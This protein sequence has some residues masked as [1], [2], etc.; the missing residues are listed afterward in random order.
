MA[1]G[2]TQIVNSPGKARNGQAKRS[3]KTV[4]P[5]NAVASNP[6]RLTPLW[7]AFFFILATALFSL[8]PRI[9]DNVRLAMSFRAAAGV[10]LVLLLLLRAQ[11][12]RTGRKLTYDFKPRSV[13]YVQLV[14]HTCVY[15]YWGW[16]WRE[17]Y[18][19]IPLIIGQIVFAYALDMIVNWFR[20]DDYV[21][22]FGPFPIILSTNLFLWF[23]DDYFYWQFVLISV[24]VLGKE[25]I[26]WKRDGRMTHIFNPS[27]LSLFVFS[28][29]LLAT[30]NT[31][32]TWGIEI[33]STF[34][35][36]PHIYMELFL[37]GLVVQALF[38]VTLVTLAAAAA[39]LL[40]N[41]AYTHTT[42]VYHF[43]DSNI[44]VAVFLGL[45]LLVTDPATSP[46][47]NFGKIIFGALYGLGVF[48]AYSALGWFGAPEFYDKLLCVPILNLFVQRLDWLSDALGAKFHSWGA[49]WKLSPRATNFA[50]MGIW[51]S[52]FA[53]MMTTGF[54]R[55]GESFPGHHPEFWQKACEQNKWNACKTWARVLNDGC[56]EGSRNACFMYGQVVDEGRIVPRNP[57]VA[58]DAFGRACDMGLPQ[59]CGNLIGF[60]QSGGKDVFFKSCYSGDGASCFILGTLYSSGMGVSQDGGQAFTLFEKSCD[61]GWWRGCGRLGK[62]YLVGQGTKAD[63]VKAIENYDKGCNGGNAA[64]CYEVAGLYQQGIGGFQDGE[65]AT[66]RLQQA[67]ELGLRVA[68]GPQRGMHRGPVPTAVR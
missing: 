63:P 20:R 44:P 66:R 1:H 56:Q 45:H 8:I 67:C 22:G 35:N 9:A 53:V 14:M 40:L 33:A 16:Y 6:E 3:A 11:V 5:T 58:G 51:T 27:A 28:I 31:G 30:K 12:S 57:A 64:S 61:L 38:G 25:F 59:G 68:C 49:S 15:A 32:M 36:P 52:L 48:A 7:L 41:L 54:L 43:V 13:H 37:L 47:R 26:K 62:S 46:R 24:G 39:L 55:K 2:S 4:P 19:A 34:H 60:A 17:V 18:R 23:H 29:V 65:M 50:C 21:L 10:L 42:G